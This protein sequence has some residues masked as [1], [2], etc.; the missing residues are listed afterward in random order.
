[1]FARY[2]QVLACYFNERCAAQSSA[3]HPS[4]VLNADWLGVYSWAVCLL[5]SPVLAPWSQA[6]YTSL[7]ALATTPSTEDSN[8]EANA[9]ALDGSQGLLTGVL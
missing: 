4:L 3:I 5:R 2:M 9:H 1:M 7:A 6:V 8:G